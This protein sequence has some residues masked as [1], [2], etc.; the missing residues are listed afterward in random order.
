M[1]SKTIKA[2]WASVFVASAIAAGTFS[3]VEWHQAGH[4]HVLEYDFCGT[5]HGPDRSQITAVRPK[6]IHEIDWIQS[7]LPPRR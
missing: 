6:E 4:R 7:R 2:T 3:H 5:Y 1:S